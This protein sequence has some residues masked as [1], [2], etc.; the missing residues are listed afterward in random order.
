TS[1]I[2]AKLRTALKSAVQKTGWKL[3]SGSTSDLDK[4]SNLARSDFDFELPPHETFDV[5]K[6]ASL[7]LQKK[8]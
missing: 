6:V 5:G 2:D 3:T 1:E 8:D 4:G 7:V